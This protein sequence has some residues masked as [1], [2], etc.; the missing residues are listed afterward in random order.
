MSYS[1]FVVIVGLVAFLVVPAQADVLLSNLGEPVRDFNT[2]DSLLWAAQSFE[3]DANSYNLTNIMALV[4]GELG[5]S[6]GF[7]QLRS[8]T[9]TGDMDTSAGGLLLTF[10]LP[11]LAGARSPRTFTPIGA[12]LLAASTRYYFVLGAT[13]PGSFE[14]SYAEGN[15]SIG[16]GSFTQFEYTFDGGVNW[17]SFD[18]EN[19]FHLQVNVTPEAVPEPS[20]STL[21]FGSAMV[22]LL[23]GRRFAFRH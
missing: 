4:G 13:G 20:S 22:L 8:S 6:G 12:L 5:S 23:A 1:R 3:T 18:N 21:L 19:P 10:T 15:G 17:G 11:G 2:L 14:W 16:P 9:A 7:A